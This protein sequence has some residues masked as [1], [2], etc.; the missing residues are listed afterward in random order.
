MHAA[1]LAEIPSYYVIQRVISHLFNLGRGGE[2]KVRCGVDGA[3]MEE[4]HFVA[5]GAVAFVEAVEAFS[6]TDLGSRWEPDFEEV[7]YVA[8]VA[9][10]VVGFEVFGSGHCG[11]GES[12][13]GDSVVGD[14][15]DLKYRNKE[16]SFRSLTFAG[17]PRSLY[18]VL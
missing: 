12:V 14:E 13:V 5:D 10:A 2:D 16:K 18:Y 3:T 1:V 9:G 8:A 4:A 15:D 17:L 11:V 6:D 7:G